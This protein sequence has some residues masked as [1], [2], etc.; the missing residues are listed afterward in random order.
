MQTLIYTVMLALYSLSALAPTEPIARMNQ[1]RAITFWISFV[2][3]MS[4]TVNEIR[5]IWSLS[6][7]DWWNSVWNRWDAATFCIYLLSVFLRFAF[8]DGLNLGRSRYLY[9]LVALMLWVRLGRQYAVSPTLGPQIIM[10]QLMVRDIMVFL[11]LMFLVF[12]GYAVALYSVLHRELDWTQDTL[13]ELA[14]Y[15]YFQVRVGV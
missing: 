12:V 15:P 14:F 1:D 9:S 11:A 13:V 4:L 8:D 5:Q 3:M 2:W 10:I 7:G 6:L